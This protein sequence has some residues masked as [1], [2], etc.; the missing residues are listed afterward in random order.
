MMILKYYN[1]IVKNMYVILLN[2]VRHKIIMILQYQ[3]AIVNLKNMKHQILVYV[4]QIIFG[5]I[6]MKKLTEM[7]LYVSV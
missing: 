1:A 2:L 5:V 3:N 7:N 6:V 4:Q